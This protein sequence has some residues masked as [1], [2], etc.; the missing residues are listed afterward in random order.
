MADKAP[1]GFRYEEGRA[2]YLPPPDWKME[3]PPEEVLQAIKDNRLA[4]SYDH[5]L[6]WVILAAA[7][8]KGGIAIPDMYREKN[9]KYQAWIVDV[10]PDAY[11]NGWRIGTK[12]RTAQHAGVIVQDRKEDNQEGRSE[13]MD[14]IRQESILCYDYSHGDSV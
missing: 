5:V 10:G 4:M 13:K 1:E 11:A 7:E 12:I 2:T 14:I 8:T 9:R 6:I 3:A